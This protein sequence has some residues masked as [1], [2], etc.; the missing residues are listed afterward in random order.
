M[1]AATERQ[2]ALETLRLQLEWGADEAL[3]E[4]PVDRTRRQAMTRPAPALVER[5]P[6]LV[7]TAAAK[8][9]RPAAAV[10][11]EEVAAA[12][13]SLQELR[14]ALGSFE[15][16]SLAATATN[17]VFADGNPGAELMFVGEAPGAEEDLSGKPFV[18]SSGQFLDRMLATIGLD[19]T[20]F[21]ITNLIPWR[22]PG[23]RNPTDAEVLIC[24]PFLFRHI[25][26]A[27][28]RRLVL[29]G[30]LAARSVLGGNAGIRRMR[31]KWVEARVP[32]LDE[33][34]P[35]LPMLH[36]AY[37]LRTPGA[38]RDMWT[39]LILLKRT[40]EADLSGT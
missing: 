26:L 37:L 17:L 27:R 32:G 6:S 29:L 23:N 3:G 14:A 34:L 35:A 22:P 16:C 15:G 19:R 40:L 31:G 8:G 4:A 2:V 21:L 1:E 33:P 36:P 28:P 18:G 7:A 10:R 20:K 39:D 25:A 5:S 9:A 11:A 30:A 24:L 12:A 13:R 38:K